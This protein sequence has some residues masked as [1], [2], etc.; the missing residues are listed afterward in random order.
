VGWIKYSGRYREKLFMLLEE[1]EHEALSFSSRFIKKPIISLADKKDSIFINTDSRDNITCAVMIT[2]N[3][4]L[5]PLIKERIKNGECSF[6]E[7][8][9]MLGSRIYLLNSIMGEQNTVDEIYSSL[10]GL[11]KSEG[12]TEYHYYTMLLSSKKEFIRP[13]FKETEKKYTLR[14][15]S[16]E[17]ISELMPLQEM[18]EKEEVLPSEELFNPD[19]ACR[20]LKNTIKQ[21]ISV[22]CECRGKIVSKANTNGS[23]INCTQIGGVFTIPEYRNRGICRLVT[24]KLTE[25]ILDGGKKPSLFVKQENKPAISVYIKL[26]FKITSGFK[27]IYL[28]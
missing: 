26:G 23:G 11:I 16:P 22:V 6:N 25:K 27:I 2:G 14:P 10:S 8:S 17:D 12:N 4:Q 9:T 15:P 20:Y 28:F 3:G 7:L 13:D 21:Q 1:K 5:L 24:G 18:Y 19:T